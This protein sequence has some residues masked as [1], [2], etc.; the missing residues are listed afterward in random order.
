MRGQIRREIHIPKQCGQLNAS[1]IVHAKEYF[2]FIAARLPSDSRKRIKIPKGPSS[3]VN[4]CVK[5][6]TTNPVSAIR[7]SI[8]IDISYL[9]IM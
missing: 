9:L 6:K 8:S 2:D 1:A 5:R 7:N 3:I 4:I